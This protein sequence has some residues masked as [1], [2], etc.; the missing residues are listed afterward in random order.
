MP[1]GTFARHGHYGEF[2]QRLVYTET[3][4][5][6][7]IYEVTLHKVAGG[8]AKTLTNEEKAGV[9][10]SRTHRGHFSSAPQTVLKTAEPT[11]TLPPP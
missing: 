1:S 5:Q 9:D 3:N 11:G 2:E 7:T 10:G 8:E 4:Q 6:M